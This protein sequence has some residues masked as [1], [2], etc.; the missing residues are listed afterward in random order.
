MGATRGGPSV[1][2]GLR[3]GSTAKSA[4]FT[5]LQLQEFEHQSLIYKY[6]AAGV[7]VPF[8]LVLPIWKS[9]ASSSLNSAALYKHYPSC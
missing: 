2:L 8:H 1:G 6:M 5:F 9:V 4:G 7:A 3:L